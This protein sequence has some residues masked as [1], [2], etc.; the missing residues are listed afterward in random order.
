MIHSWRILL[1]GTCRI[2]S[3]VIKQKL[4]KA[5]PSSA[6]NRSRCRQAAL[7]FV[8]DVSLALSFEC[9]VALGLDRWWVGPFRLLTLLVGGLDFDFDADFDADF[10]CVVGS[11]I[12]EVSS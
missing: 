3:K 9:S 12:D 5:S 7:P 1:I 11:C 10:E 4:L 2:S 6:L 8:L